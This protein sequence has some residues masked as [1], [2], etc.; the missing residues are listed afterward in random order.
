MNR[1][2][3]LI[4]LAAAVVMV[5]AGC[6]RLEPRV[7]KAPEQPAAEQ[8]A[9][10]VAPIAVIALNGGAGT[11]MRADQTE[12]LLDGL[13]V[14]PGDA[15]TATSGTVRI[16]YTGAGASELE[17]GTTVTVLPD[18][19]GNGSVFVQIE[20]AAGSIWTRFERLLGSDERFSVTGNNVVATVRGTAFGMELV[21]TEADVQVAEN[22]VD[23][24]P[25]R[26]GV[27]LTKI[28]ATVMVSHGEGLRIGAERLM[29]LDVAAAKKLVRTLGNAE[30]K[31]AGFAFMSSKLS[32]AL[33][34]KRA[35]VR[36]DLLPNIPEKFRDR[37]DPA[38][39][40]RIL[41]IR[42]LQAN[43]A[44]VAPFR[45]ILPSDRA[46]AL[47]PSDMVS[48]TQQTSGDLNLLGVP[49]GR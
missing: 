38:L 9:G 22:V 28:A 35:S 2:Y 34:K 27:D 33:L 42:A 1:I 3:F 15:I 11:V 43:P 44:F 6:F 19:K 39:L 5:G 29:K 40:E 46:P 25:F 24:R 32:D 8:T 49:A 23:I 21:D 30:R 13:E 18:G 7:A 16:V 14:M 48:T 26:T 41:K 10:N 31:R 12:S 4:V 45:P 36:W 17:Q 37:I 20:L 47:T